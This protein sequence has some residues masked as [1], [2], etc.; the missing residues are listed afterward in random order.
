MYERVVK[1]DA[2]VSYILQWAY[3]CSVG[4][5]FWLFGLEPPGFNSCVSC[6]SCVVF[7]ISSSNAVMLCSSFMCAICSCCSFSSFLCCVMICCWT[8]CL[9]SNLLP[10][11]VFL[12]EL[13]KSPPWPLCC[14]SW[15]SA[16][17]GAAW[18]RVTCHGWVSWATAPTGVLF[19]RTAEASGAEVLDPWWSSYREGN[20]RYEGGIICG[21]NTPKKA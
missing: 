8:A 3:L 10:D 13:V 21:K 4:S 18:R 9:F 12:F 2:F 17:V 15:S 16:A 19:W 20:S 1:Y 14:A 7:S 11:T 6:V 5:E